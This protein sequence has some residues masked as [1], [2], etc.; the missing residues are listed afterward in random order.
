LEEIDREHHS[1]TRDPRHGMAE[2][3]ALVGRVRRIAYD[4]TLAPDDQM[5]RIRDLFLD[6]DHPECRRRLKPHERM[7]RTCDRWCGPSGFDCDL[8]SN[9]TTRGPTRS[10][11]VA[12]G[13]ELWTDDANARRPIPVSG[14]RRTADG[15]RLFC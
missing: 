9:F 8:D 12:V 6:Y 5:R 2:L 1:T 13:R 10:R 11:L 7:A 4:F 3:L 14:A 15:R